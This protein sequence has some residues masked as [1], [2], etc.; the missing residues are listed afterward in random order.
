LHAQLDDAFRVVAVAELLQGVAGESGGFIRVAVVEHGLNVLDRV[1]RDAFLIDALLELGDLALDELGVLK[2]LGR[3][4][5]F[6]GL[7]PVALGERGKGVGEGLFVFLLLLVGYVGG[8]FGASAFDDLLVLFVFGN[9]LP[10]E[11]DVLGIDFDFLIVGVL[12]GLAIAAEEEAEGEEA[13]GGDDA[14]PSHDATS[15]KEGK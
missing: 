7:V 8:D 3:L 9:R 6:E 12:R 15:L 14:E 4:E 5:G 11:L 2:R 1:L 13:N 10:I